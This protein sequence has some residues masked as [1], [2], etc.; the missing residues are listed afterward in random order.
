MN[1]KADKTCCCKLPYDTLLVMDGLKRA[2]VFVIHMQSTIVKLLGT[3]N[4][5]AN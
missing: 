5:S 2:S 4:L 3:Y 1:E